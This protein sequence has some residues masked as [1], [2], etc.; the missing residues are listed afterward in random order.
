MSNKLWIASTPLGTALRC[1]TIVLLLLLLA[2]V[3]F[4]SLQGSLAGQLRSGAM[5]SFETL[6]IVEMSPQDDYDELVQRALFSSDRKPKNS[7]QQT[8]TLMTGKASEN[9]LLVGVIKSGEASYAIF[10]EKLGERR[11]NLELG[12]L[13]DGWKVEAISSDQVGLIKDGEE[14]LL[15]LL[16]SEP[17]KTPKRAVKR[18]ARSPVRPERRRVL[19]SRAAS[20]K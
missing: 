2:E 4:F 16:I 3:V 8:Q 9:W 12:M 19:N 20:K 17:K 13:L 15:R 7:A 10:S 6:A 14:D 5:P 1:A 11:L 18:S